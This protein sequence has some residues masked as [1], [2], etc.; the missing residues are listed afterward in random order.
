MDNKRTD[1][2]GNYRRYE[3]RRVAMM[4]SI[5]EILF[6]KEPGQERDLAILEAILFNFETDRAAFVTESA[7]ENQLKFS[8]TAGKWSDAPEE[9]SIKGEGIDKFISVHDNAPGALTIARVKR[10]SVFPVEI[11]SDLWKTG[12]DKSTQALLSV[13]ICP[14]LS[15]P[16]Y[17]WLFQVQYSR[18]WSSR[19]RN[20]SE[21]MAKALAHVKDKES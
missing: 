16:Y 5:Y 1:K 21:E 4:L 19:D 13:K 17:L 20:L 3:D 15:S 6:Y 12:L 10:P 14:R 11:W 7:K 9:F 8:C 18:E 2:R